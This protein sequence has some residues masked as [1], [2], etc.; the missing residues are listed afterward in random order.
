MFYIKNNHT[1]NSRG[2]NYTVKGARICNTVGLPFF[3]FS[4]FLFDQNLK[5]IFIQF[6]I[7]LDRGGS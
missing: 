1:V 2:T 6:F 7:T 3:L 5:S 4:F